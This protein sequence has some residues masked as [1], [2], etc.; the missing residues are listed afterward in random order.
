M[1]NVV[2]MGWVM[3]QGHGYNFFRPICFWVGPQK[4]GEKSLVKSFLFHI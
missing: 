3:G 4:E 1:I 2:G